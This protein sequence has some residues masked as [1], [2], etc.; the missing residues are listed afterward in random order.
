MNP[1]VIEARTVL[2][3]DLNKLNIELSIKAAIDYYRQLYGEPV[4]VWVNAK[5][6][7]ETITEV[8]GHKIEKRNGCSRNKIMVF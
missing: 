8:D 1:T 4:R 3:A 6:V 2:F 7:P 5:D